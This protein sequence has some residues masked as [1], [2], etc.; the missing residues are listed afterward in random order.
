V[1][2]AAAPGSGLAPAV[3]AVPKV[4]LGFGLVTGW[5]RGGGWVRRW[6][7]EAAVAPPRGQAAG[8]AG[9]A[10]WRRRELDRG[11]GGRVASSP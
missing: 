8:G 3:V 10:G 7:G 11:Q 5:L 4:E 6:A 9:E 1:D 2:A